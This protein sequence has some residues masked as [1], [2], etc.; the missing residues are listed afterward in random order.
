MRKTI[1]SAATDDM[2]QRKQFDTI[3]PFSTPAEAK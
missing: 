3:N 2:M 1:S